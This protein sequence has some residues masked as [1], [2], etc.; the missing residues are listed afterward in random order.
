MRAKFKKKNANLNKDLVCGGST[1]PSMVKD[2]IFALFNFGT[3]PLESYSVQFKK[4]FFAAH[5]ENK[6]NKQFKKFALN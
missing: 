5:Q 4:K 6:K 1:T 2:H 3:L